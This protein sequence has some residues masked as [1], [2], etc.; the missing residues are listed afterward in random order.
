VVEGGSG[1]AGGGLARIEKM[2]ALQPPRPAPCARCP[3]G[4]AGAELR[5]AKY[6]HRDSPVLASLTRTAWADLHGFGPLYQ[7]EPARLAA[8]VEDDQA[9]VS[10]QA[11][12]FAAAVPQGRVVRIPHANHFV[13]WSN[14]GEVVK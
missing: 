11:D 8:L 6:K 9:H 12:A 7:D 14:E 13:F 10:A 3:D 4:W 2:V 5:Y 1:A